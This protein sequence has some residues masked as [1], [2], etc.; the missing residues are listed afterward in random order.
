VNPA[1]YITLLRV[2]ISPLFLCFYLFYPEMGLSLE[3]AAIILLLLL[4]FLEAS[5][6]VDG[7]IARKYNQVT[8]L[9]KLL[10][11]MADSIYR[12]SIFLTFSQPP[13]SL[14]LGLVFVFL[15]RDSLIATLRTVCALKGMVLAA[16]PSGKLKAIFQGMA[17]LT[18]TWLLW[19]FSLG[20]LPLSDLRYWSALVVSLAALYT[21][22]SGVEYII[23]NRRYLR[24]I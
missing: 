8:D 4:L 10:D 7:Y 23:A 1:H 20:T 15:Y 11:P 12:I 2:L 21:A 16:R 19:R 17:A 22:L 14:P 3:S 5:D 24:R 9:G 13:V 18:V 6:A